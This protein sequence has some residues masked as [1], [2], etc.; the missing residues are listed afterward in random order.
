MAEDDKFSRVTQAQF[1]LWMARDVTK[2]FLQCFKWEIEH[3]DEDIMPVLDP[4]SSDASHAF[5]FEKQGAIAAFERCGDPL[6]VLKRS[7]R[8]DDSERA[9]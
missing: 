3:I 1:E 9:N 8:Y 2:I 7:G 4:N 6:T 5:L